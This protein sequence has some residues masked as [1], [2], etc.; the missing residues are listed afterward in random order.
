MCELGNDQNRSTPLRQG[1]IHL[2]F[3]VAEQ[4]KAGGLLG[5]PV[6]LLRR[7]AVGEANEKKES[8]PDAPR[9]PVVNADFRPR[10]PLE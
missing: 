5:H 4:S 3:G 10:D 8:L 1:E 2:P 9:F 6:D 7:V